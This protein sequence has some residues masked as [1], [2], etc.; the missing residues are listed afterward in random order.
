MTDYASQK[1]KLKVGKSKPKAA[2][3][4][5]TSFKAKSI[6]LKKQSLNESAPGPGAQIAH[7]TS[8]LKNR[9]SSQRHDSLAF[10]TNLSTAELCNAAPELLPKLPPLIHDESSSVRQQLMKLFRKV[11]EQKVL[12]VTEQILLWSRAGITHLSTEIQI[13]SLE[14]LEWLLSV[15]GE[16]LFAIP[17]SWNGLLNSFITVCGW[18]GNLEA[19]AKGWST[20]KQS[21]RPGSETK[22][23]VK[24]FSALHALFK[25]GLAASTETELHTP[26]ECT[27]WV[28]Y[29]LPQR[30]NAFAHL[31]LFGAQ[32]NGDQQ[33]FDDRED[34]QRY[35]HDHFENKVQQGVGQALK[36][37]G[38]LGRGSSALLKLL[39]TTMAA[40]EE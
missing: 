2:N 12:S 38:E 3:Y 19:T 14:V 21:A 40:F 26:F 7:H 13:F 28:H 32:A 9:I 37:G 31:D 4:T 30:P 23:L 20:Q 35:F 8:L 36:E 27:M 6:T 10:L 5:D 17:G 29:G 39:K 25:A 22:I 16:D 15:T 1:A 24:R 34:R 18:Q 11:P 33:I